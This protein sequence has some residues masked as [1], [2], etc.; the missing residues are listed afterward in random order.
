[1]KFFKKPFVYAIIFS[2]LLTSLNVYILLKT[3]VISD[4]I[5]VVETNMVD[6]TKNNILEESDEMVENNILGESNEVVENNNDEADEKIIE[7]T[8]TDTSYTDE[9]IN[10]SINTIYRNNTYIY[11]VDVQ[12]SSPEYLK[13]ALAHNSFGTDVTQTTSEMANANNAILAI[14]G[15]YYGANTR[16]YVIKQ[17]SLYRST[18]KSNTE[19]EDLVI[20]ED[21]SFGIINETEISAEELIEKGVVNTLTFGPTLVL[22]GGI[23]VSENDEVAKSQAEN[24]RTAIGI[25]DNLHYIFLVSDGRT[26]ESEG[27]SLYQVAEIMQ[28]YGCKIAY[29][30]DGGGSSTLYFNG[31]VI[32]NPTTS[33]R[34]IKER[35]VSDIVY[36][37]Y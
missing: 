2:I 25:V 5:T 4:V 37:G 3:F 17:G 7:S 23:V 33:G 19:Y 12:I 20:Y 14:N 15:D 10:I 35:S 11:V 28:E 31:K 26:E 13:T 29:N 6:N 34:I 24:P 30:L 1:M 9:N 8:I 18:V 22:D 16:G 27:L 36:I 32:N 21:G